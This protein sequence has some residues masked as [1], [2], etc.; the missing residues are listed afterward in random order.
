MKLRDGIERMHK[1]RHDVEEAWENRQVFKDEASRAWRELPGRWRNRDRTQ[2]L[3][4]VVAGVMVI[5]III[6]TLI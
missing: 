6:L 1:A 4:I 5:G 3:T 2:T